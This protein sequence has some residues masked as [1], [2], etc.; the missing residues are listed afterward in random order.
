MKFNLLPTN[1]VYSLSH[2][3]E[4]SVTK[5][6]SAVAVTNETSFVLFIFGSIMLLFWHASNTVYVFSQYAKL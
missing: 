5:R 4:K 6:L 3:L 2:I 1:L